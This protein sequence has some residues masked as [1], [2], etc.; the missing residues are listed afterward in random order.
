MGM[1]PSWMDTAHEVPDT[2]LAELL[3]VQVARTP[4]APAVE[5]RGMVQTYA[6]FAA[7]VEALSALLRRHGAC[8]GRIVAVALPRSIEL[9]VALHAVIRSGAAYL[10]VD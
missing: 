6:E 5:F 3:H 8:R 9:V 4:D 7:R 2:T 1:M 10:P